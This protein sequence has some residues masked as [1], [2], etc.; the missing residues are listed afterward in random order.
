MTPSVTT[1]L[2]RQDGIALVTAVLMLLLMSVL[3]ATFMVISLSERSSSS[4]VQT[5]RMATHA[6]D[7]G[8][9]TAQQE[10]ANVARARLD[11]LTLAWSGSGPLVASPASLFPVG[12][13]T[14]SSTNPK[15]QATASVAFVTS[16]TSSASQTFDYRYTIRSEGLGGFAGQRNIESTGILRVSASRGSFTD[17]LVY[18]NQHTS[19]SGGAIWFTS[20]TNFDGRVHTNGK[21][22][23]AWQPTFHDLVTSVSSTAMYNNDGDPVELAANSNGTLDVP[24]FYGG[25]DRGSANVALPTNAFGQMSAALGLPAASTARPNNSDVNLR[26]GAGTNSSSPA[27]GIYL[28]NSLGA[29]TGGIYVHGDLDRCALSIDGSGRQVYFLQ[30]GGTTR[31]ITVDRAANRTYV[32]SGTGP[33]SYNGV[34][35]GVLYVEGSIDDLRGPDRVGGEVVP[36]LA[37]GTRLLITAEDDIRIER[38]ITCDNYEAATNVLGLFTTNGGVHVGGTAPDN[39]KLDAYVMAAGSSGVFAVDNH[40]MGDPR[41]LFQLRGGMV[42]EFYG[43][44]GTFNQAG[45]TSGYGRDFHFDRRGLVPPYFPMTNRYTADIPSARTVTWI[46][47]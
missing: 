30:Q 13:I 4:N 12:P 10:L 32:D 20:N 16:D 9:R 44:F 19:T 31:T 22:R 8:V 33:V 46:E 3:G 26:I 38:D 14:I 43:A 47:V 18:T 24:H 25:F 6:A 23:F 21:F 29:L 35:Q 11:S 27:D 7:A 41:G 28:P 2:S 5:A 36:A 1:R 15:F 37:T 34:P 40:N 39:M 17:Y 42:T 45:I